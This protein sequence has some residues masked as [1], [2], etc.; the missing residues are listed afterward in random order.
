MNEFSTRLKSLL[1]KR[2]ITQKKL[3]EML[4]TTGA[5]VS[6]YVNGERSPRSDTLARMAVALN[7][8]TDYLLGLSDSPRRRRR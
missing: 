4:G 2:G 7:T 5:A 3:A 1:K 6:R 8:S